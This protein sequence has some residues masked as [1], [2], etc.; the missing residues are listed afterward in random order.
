M[1]F[2][3][4]MLSYLLLNV[5]IPIVPRGFLP[6][7]CFIMVFFRFRHGSANRNNY[8]AWILTPSHSGVIRTY[9]HALNLAPSLF[10]PVMKA[11]QLRTCTTRLSFSS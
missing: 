3:V 10:I 4:E 1:S 2:E 6:G 11:K 7:N 9:T 5:S 8:L